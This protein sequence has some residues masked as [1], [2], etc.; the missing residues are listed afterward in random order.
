MALRSYCVKLE[1]M[2]ETPISIIQK[3]LLVVVLLL[4][5]MLLVVH[6]SSHHAQHA[7]DNVPCELCLAADNLGH[8]LSTDFTQ[9]PVLDVFFVPEK[10]LYTHHLFIFTPASPLPRSPPLV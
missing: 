9:C 1:D 3:W 7:A 4:T 8:G 2:R 6:A 10:T 5:Q